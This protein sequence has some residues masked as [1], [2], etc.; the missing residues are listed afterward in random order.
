MDYGQIGASS[1][2]NIGQQ[3]IKLQFDQERWRNGRQIDGN[4]NEVN[5]K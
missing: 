3:K 2:D 4:E 1:K 5:L